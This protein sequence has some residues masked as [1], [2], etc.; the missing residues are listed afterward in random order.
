MEFDSRA[1]FFHSVPFDFIDFDDDFSI[2]TG[3]ERAGLAGPVR[4]LW[5]SGSSVKTRNRKGSV[6][7]RTL[8][9]RYL[10]QFFSMEDKINCLENEFLCVCLRTFYR[11]GGLVF[12]MDDHDNFPSWMM[13]LNN[14]F[15][16]WRMIRYS[17]HWVGDFLS[18]S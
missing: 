6:G 10:S 5:T 2:G 9:L 13:T 17:S 3:I 8:P 15:S 4:R 1:S 11:R 18:L 7:A 16:Y 12:I 14:I